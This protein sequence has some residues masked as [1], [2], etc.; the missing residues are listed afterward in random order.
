MSPV[1]IDAQRNVE[2]VGDGLR[3]DLNGLFRLHNWIK[4]PVYYT[5]G[6]LYRK[7]KT[8]GNG[9]GVLAKMVCAIYKVFYIIESGR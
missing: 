4:R 5:A 1:K 7:K 8:L 6:L 3:R 9:D 2:T